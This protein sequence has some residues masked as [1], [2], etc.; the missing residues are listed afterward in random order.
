[1]TMKKL[2]GILNEI[3]RPGER[4]FLVGG[5][6]R[7]IL[8]GR[9]TKDIDLVTD[10]NPRRLAEQIAR[11]TDGRPFTLHAE[12][13]AYRV[14]PRPGKTGIPV[15]L[16]PLVGELEED[17]RRRDFTI[18]AMALP[19]PLDL[20]DPERHLVDPVGGLTDLRARCIRH[21]RAEAFSEDPV[22]LLRAVRIAAT[23]AFDIATETEALVRAQAPLLSGSA[24]ERV[25]DELFLLLDAKDA[26]AW[27]RRLDDLGL[28]ATVI[29]ELEPL[30]G[31][32]QNANHHLDV[33][34]HT[35][36]ALRQCERLPWGEELPDD[37]AKKARAL[38][39]QPVCLPRSRAALLL[40]ATLLH[41]VAK[42]QTRGMTAEGVITFR[43]HDTV[44]EEVARGI[45][46]RLR[47]SG[48]ETKAVAAA[49]RGHL[50]PGFLAWAEPP[51]LLPR[52]HF[53]RDT[54]AAALETLLLSL[55]DRLAARG[56]AA[57]AERIERHRRFV[58][59]M[60]RLYLDKAPV[61]CP[62][63]PASG[64]EIMAAAGLPQGPAL[65]DLLEALREA[66]AIGEIH[67]HEEALRFAR[68]HRPR[69]EVPPG[70]SP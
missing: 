32:E 70:G 26:A 65:G 28:L 42:P 34:E 40:F 29:P 53:F 9:A 54:G 12:I 1:M 68:Q 7:D 50:L 63:V 6:V 39:A 41:D 35:L 38:L 13:R 8:L 5:C 17:L 10:G 16:L 19:L 30:K 14:V 45:C 44:G 43:G 66:V 46:Q 4:V 57:T 3:V 2:L 31:L 59:E 51:A 64:R 25:R 22:R 36:D 52:Y 58:I 24:A 48:R 15:D 56:T 55:A 33:W 21:M 18:N 62:V 60:L 11:R 23:L 47:L 61:A 27:V 37:V 69:T 20:A 67:T 49:V